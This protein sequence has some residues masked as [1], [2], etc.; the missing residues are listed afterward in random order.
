[1]LRPIRKRSLPPGDKVPVKPYLLWSEAYAI[2]VESI[3]DDHQRLFALVNEF[4]VAVQTGQVPKT[5][6]A[7]LGEL[8]RYTIQHF[9]REE[10]TM[11]SASYPGLDQ[12]KELHARLRRAVAATLKSHDVAARLFDYAGFIGFLKNWLTNHILVEDRKFADYLARSEAT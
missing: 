10:A 3:D 2:G 4:H 11:Q 12:H 5:I 6:R 9:D 1:M 7:T 8:A